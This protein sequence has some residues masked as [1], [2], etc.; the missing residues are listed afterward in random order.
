MD[1]ARLVGHAQAGGQAAHDGQHTAD[2][3][4]GLPGDELRQA[5]A[6]DQ[7]HQ[8]HLLPLDLDHAVDGDHVGVS[9][10]AREP[11]L[12]VE[13]VGGGD[14]AAVRAVQHLAGEDLAVAAAHPVDRGH[15]AAPELLAHLV[16][17]LWHTGIIHGRSLPSRPNGEAAPVLVVG[18]SG[19]LRERPRG[20]HGLRWASR[21]SGRPP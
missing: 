7:L 11:G 5:L 16:V 2:R 18:P 19:D 13:S 21:S 6:L 15:R 8:Q 9:Q 12:Q 4:R 17:A 1:D 14:V 3:K 20:D 10:A